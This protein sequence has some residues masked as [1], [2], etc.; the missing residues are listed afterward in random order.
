[1]PLTY[2]FYPNLGASRLRIYESCKNSSDYLTLLSYAGVWEVPRT[3][4]VL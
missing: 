3:D 1:M 2:L 4:A